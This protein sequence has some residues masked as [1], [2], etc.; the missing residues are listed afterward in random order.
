M[1]YY[2]SNF[3]AT[4]QSPLLAGLLAESMNREANAVEGSNSV[5]S[6]ARR[7]AYKPGK[8]F[9]DSLLEPIKERREREKKKKKAMERQASIDEKAAIDKRIDEGVYIGENPFYDLEAEGDY[10]K[11]FY[12]TEAIYND[13]VE[14]AEGDEYEDSNK[15]KQWDKGERYKPRDVTG[16]RINPPEE[17]ADYNNP[18]YLTGDPKKDKELIENIEWK[19]EGLLREAMGWEPENIAK[20]LG[21]NKYFK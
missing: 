13:L 12:G 10:T 2:D 8:S 19:K 16:W 5:M 9:W 14:Y 6:N 18:L 4:F 1:S 20:R 15:N 3:G 7:G 21:V 11:D 17:F